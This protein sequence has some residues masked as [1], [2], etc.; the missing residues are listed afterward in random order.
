MLD[1]GLEED[2]EVPDEQQEIVEGTEAVGD[3][4]VTDYAAAGMNSRA[5][6]NGQ[7]TDN[8]RLIEAVTGQTFVLLVMRLT[9]HIC[10][11]HSY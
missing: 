8:V 4:D 1:D 9:G 7:S 3:E 11:L 2:E 5:Q 6:N 10:W